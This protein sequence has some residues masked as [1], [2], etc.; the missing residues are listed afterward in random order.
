MTQSRNTKKSPGARGF[1]IVELL[2]VIVVIAILAAISVV[3]YNGIQ[4]RSA[5]SA[6]VSDVREIRKALELYKIDHGVYPANFAPTFACTPPITVGYSYSFATDGSWLK[7]LV[8]EKYLQKAPVPPKNGCEQYFQYMRKDAT[9]YGCT[10]RATGWYVLIVRGASGSTTPSDSKSFKPCA[11]SS[12]GWFTDSKTWV[13]SG[14][15]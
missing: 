12:V 11:E 8:D 4:G 7:Q 15:E 2:I 9:A 13:F 10:S 1:T 14:N 5:D 6:L 3:A